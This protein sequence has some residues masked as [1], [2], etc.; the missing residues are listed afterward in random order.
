[1]S[2]ANDIRRLAK[3]GGHDLGELCRATKVE[4]FSG[5]TADTRVD[6]GRLRGNWQTQEG[7]KPSGAIERTDKTGASVNAEINATASKDGVTYFVNNLPYAKK[8]EEEDAMV[9]RNVAR[10]RQI[11]RAL[12]AKIRR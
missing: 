3:K 12:A 1:M 4:L 2:W 8:W 10:V 11:V 5:V 9:G 7:R 6:T